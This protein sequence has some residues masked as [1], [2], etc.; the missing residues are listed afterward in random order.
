MSDE[1]VE[2]LNEFARERHPGM[3]GVE[4]LTCEPEEVTGR[5]DVR[6]ELV[7]GTGFLWAPV[8]V[9][10]A[11]WLVACGTPLHMEP[12]DLFTTLEFK[13]NFLGTV[14]EGGAI[15]G[16]ARPA[17]VGRTTQVWDVEV[18]DEATGRTIALFRGT[19]MI[20]RGRR[21]APVST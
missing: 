9:T 7:A 12:D 16:C 11:D 18:T 5:L 17:H 3:V 13:S 20:L 15:R 10:L 21:Q 4:I 19:Q 2:E 1:R 14:R 6:G 8:V